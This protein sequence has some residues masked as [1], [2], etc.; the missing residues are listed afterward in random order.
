MHSLYLEEIIHTLR[1]SKT[2]YA[3]PYEF[4]NG[5]FLRIKSS[6][7]NKISH[8]LARTL[9]LQTALM[10]FTFILALRKEA[11]YFKTMSFGIA[12]SYC[13]T[14]TVGSIYFNKDTVQS[15]RRC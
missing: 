11:S 2:F 10:C 14:V 8:I 13:V 7:Y 5:Y 15:M 9:Q 3:T 12:I 4:R 6:R 1:R